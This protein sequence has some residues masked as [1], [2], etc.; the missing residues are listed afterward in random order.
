METLHTIILGSCK[1]LLKSFMS[2]RTAQEK[3]EILARISAFNTSG[4]SVRMY[5][6]VCHYYQSFVGRDFKG[7]MQ[8]ALFVIIPY[9]SQPEKEVWCL[10]SKVV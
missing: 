9:L 7:W 8:M 3:K 10:L 5:G 4:F 6:N 2:K 1:Y